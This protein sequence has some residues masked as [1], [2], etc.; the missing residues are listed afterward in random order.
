MQSD[1]FIRPLN[2]N[3]ELDL[4]CSIP[5]VINHEIPSDLDCGRRRLEWLWVA[6]QNERLLGRI[7]W[8]TRSAGESPAVLDIFDIAGLD[9]HASD[10]L[11]ATAMRAVLPRDVTPPWYIRFLAPDWHEDS[12]EVREAARRSAALG[13]FVARPLA[14]RLRFQG[15]SAPPFL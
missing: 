4:F 3:E 2:G 5:Y 8:W 1:F 10:A 7:G 15:M 14:E 11:V 13:R 6:V 9:D 12:A